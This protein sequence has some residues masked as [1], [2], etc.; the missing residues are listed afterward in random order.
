[1]AT[2][3]YRRIF[4]AILVLGL[5]AVG[6]F[7]V[8]P[9]INALLGAAILAYVFHPFFHKLARR[10]GPNTSA[11]LVTIVAVLLISVPVVI[12]LHTAAREVRDVYLKTRDQLNSSAGLQCDSDAPSTLCKL[13]TWITDFTNTKD[14]QAFAKS[15]G[16]KALEF[17]GQKG[18]TVLLSLPK[19]LVNLFVLLFTLFFLLRDGDVFVQKLY[20]ILPFSTKH[21]A[22][23]KKQ[24]SDVIYATVYGSV[25]VALVQ[26]VCAGIGFWYFGVPHYVVW[27]IVTAVFALI[28]FV[29]SWV[30]W[31]PLV[32]EYV[33]AAYVA[34]DTTLLWNGFAFFLYGAIVIS[35][36]DN[37]LKPYLIG[38]RARVHPVL[39]M[40]GALG[41]ILVFG[42]IGF[43]IGPLAL[44]LIKLTI[45]L[46]EQELL[47]V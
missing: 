42:P 44:A 8:Q 36:V 25:I 41:G 33:F 29:G 3:L 34:G 32:I 47:K 17:F 35:G 14:L 15:L 13:G 16:T 27:G 24:I 7:I 23:I 10:T 2:D 38:D 28:P 22:R 45:E 40:L 19:T 21:H 31:L 1:M 5:L 9:F 20:N 18:S 30:V 43:I 12:V 39:I 6:F 11:A 4:L 26:G 37:L 46:Y